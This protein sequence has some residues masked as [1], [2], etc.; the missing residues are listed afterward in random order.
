MTKK[1]KP[2]TPHT[3]KVSAKTP[4]KKKLTQEELDAIR[5]ANLRPFTKGDPRINRKGRIKN[6][7]KL[8]L[9]LNE[10]LGGLT[11]DGDDSGISEVIKN[12]FEQAKNPKN[13]RAVNAAAML[14]DR[15]YGKVPQTIS[16]EGDEAMKQITGFIITTKTNTNDES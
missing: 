15:A 1:K 9:V 6:L 4:V 7:P 2:N 5:D 11:E 3:K 16:V 12:I 10:I 14:L 13:R 8:K